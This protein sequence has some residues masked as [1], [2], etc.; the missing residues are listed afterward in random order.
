MEKLLVTLTAIFFLVYGIL[1]ALFPSLFASYVTNTVPLTTSG[2]IDMRATYGGM[3]IAVGILMLALADNTKTLD[4]GLL[5]V[6]VVLL[7]MATTRML[8][9][10]VDG[11][12]NTLML[13]YLAAEIVPSIA[14][15]VLYQRL[16]KNY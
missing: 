12:P 5:S 8:G 16:R 1:F 15:M 6:A 7:C 9:I 11:E 2:L 10:V 3:S 13:V 14:A 4:L